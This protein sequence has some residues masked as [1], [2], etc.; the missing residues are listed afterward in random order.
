[1]QLT[2]IAIYRPVTTMMVTLALMFLGVVSYRELPVQRM[3]EV[4]FPSMYYF[5]WIEG[6]ELSPDE[7]NDQ[8]TRPFEKL[9]AELPGVKEMHSTTVPGQFYGYCLFEKGADMRFRVIELQDKAAKWAAGRKTLHF[10]IVPESTGEDSGRLMQLVVSVPPGQEARAGE[11]CDLLSRKIRSIDGIY[12]VSIQGD[13]V[14]HLDVETER[15]ALHA[16]GLDVAQVLEAINTHAVEKKWL[17]TLKDGARDHPVQLVAKVPSLDELLKI[18]LDP[19]GIYTL[20][21]LARVRRNVSER[22]SIFRLNGKKAVHVSINMEKDR[23]A[24]VM[25]RL[26]RQRIK[27]IKAQL[28][29]GFELTVMEDVAESLESMMKNLTEMALTGA[30]LA[31]LVLLVFIRNV[32]LALVVLITIPASILITFN[33][34][35]GLGLS[36][37]ILSLLGM[38]AGVGMLVDNSIV[39]VENVFRHARHHKDPREATYLGSREVGRAILISTATH[40]VVFVPLIYLDDEKIVL[41][42]DMALSLVFPFTISLLVAIT[43]IPALTA[44]LIGVRPGQPRRGRLA[45]FF[46]SWARWNPWHRPGRAPRNFFR[47][48]IFTCAK[49]SLRHPIR[50]F[51]TLL[52][53]L[54]LTL[55]AGSIRLAIQGKME[56]E[57]TEDLVLYGKPPLGADLQEADRFFQDKEKQIHEEVSHGD[58]FEYFSSRFDKDGGQITFRVAKKYRRLGPWDFY[59]AYGKKFTSGNDSSGFRFRPFPAAHGQAMPSSP[60]QPTAGSE[61]VL[62]T[63]ENSEALQLAAGQVQTLLKNNQ[64]IGEFFL[65]TPAGQSEVHYSPDLELF[66][67]FKTDPSRLGT[68][69]AAS[70]PRGIETALVLREGDLDQRVR[71]KVLEP[72]SA[73]KPQARQTLS[74]LLRSKVL[75]EGGAVAPLETLGTFSIQPATPVIVKKNRQRNVQVTFNLRPSFY[76]PGM[77]KARQAALGRIQGEL[78]KMRLPAAISAQM[79]GTLDE[80]AAE[81]TLWK[82]VVG[83][84]I[85]AI[86][87]VMA[88]FF[89]SLLSPLIILWTLPLAFI[90]GVWGIILLGAQLD[91]VALLG[92]IILAGL[93]VNNGILLI[94]YTQQLRQG[95]GFRRPRAL[96]SAIAYRLRPIMMTS[97]TTIL[98]LLPILFSKESEDAARS[99]VAVMIGGMMVS[100]LLTLVVIP[101]FFNVSLIGLE[102]LA[103]L[104]VRLAERSPRRGEARRL[105]APALL[106]PTAPPGAPAGLRIEILNISKIY[107]LMT[108]KKLFSFIPSRVYPYGRRPLSG[109]NALKNVT[110]TIEPGM[111]GLLGPNGAGKTTLMKIITGL[112]P[113]T[114]GVARVNGIDL[115]ADRESVRGQI[116]YLPQN[117]GVYEA[118]TLNQYLD[119][120]APFY[121]LNERAERRR[122]IDEVTEWVGLEAVRDKPMKRFSG[123]MRQRAGIAQVLLRPAPII[124]VDEPTAGLDPVE[125]V[126]FRLLLAQLA[127]TRIVLLSTHI[128]DDITSSCREVAVLNRGSVVYLGDIEQVKATAEGVIWDLTCPADAP[129]PIAPRS[130]LYKKHVAGRILYHY[131]ATEPLPGSQPVEPGFED[132]YVA[133]LLRHDLSR[134]PEPPTATA[135]ADANRA[136]LDEPVIPRV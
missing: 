11:V 73:R 116:S 67:I 44:R 122:R 35:Y 123:G 63:G 117:F 89:E 45:A 25:A 1:M 62:V 29:P 77:E 94:E 104:R 31:M 49:G 9:V 101:T 19:R 74:E 61:Q 58:V 118:L 103:A 75:L 26:V 22:E 76:K 3:P 86:Y 50:L 102:R 136:A 48:F 130:I 36:I 28:P 51:F 124:I 12:Q 59:A 105:G 119:F 13:M 113:Q 93:V 95:Q 38:T 80:V 39:V 66:R 99:L 115:R 106:A 90:G 55:F 46:S 88:F 33:I 6:S 71:I 82:K 21:S 111:F 114:Y 72:K 37:N 91:T 107:P 54:L 4:T 84:A 47:E 92:T 27:E 128:V 98:G 56:R 109:N 2:R 14:Q 127:R 24:I 69:L 126:R 32:R 10:E 134:Q 65:D 97:L 112:I 135:A 125:R 53:T 23:N 57:Q 100:T 64:D 34:M 17:G 129:P 79:A 131:Y 5:V 87:F 52:V 41:L 43:L 78:A 81:T 132:A 8:L 133:L 18:P 16:A 60:Q 15:D 121:G 85:L 110:L 83:A 30:L 40:L 108:R 96:L 120:F 68:D 20:G 7:I 42:R 70:D